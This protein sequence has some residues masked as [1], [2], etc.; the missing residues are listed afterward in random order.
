MEDH[1]RPADVNKPLSFRA[2]VQSPDKKYIFYYSPCTGYTCGFDIITDN[3][4]VSALELQLL[5]HTDPCMFAHTQ[6]CQTTQAGATYSCGLVSKVNWFLNKTHP[7]IFT[8]EYKGGDKC[9]PIAPN[10]E[11]RCDYESHVSYE[12]TSTCMTVLCRKSVFTFYE[13]PSI[14]LPQLS[15]TGE[16]PELQ[17]VC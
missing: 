2:T 3:N 4:A 16:Q 15:Y 11:S 12:L 10:N 6:V 9:C 13:D 5:L 14:D 1:H 7:Y 17:Y 8:I